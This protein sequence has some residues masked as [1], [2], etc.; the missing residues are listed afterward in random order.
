MMTKNEIDYK[1]VKDFFDADVRKYLPV[2]F[3]LLRKKQIEKFGDNYITRFVE[4]DFYNTDKMAA[5]II[6]K[7]ISNII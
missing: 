3:S 2:Q 4:C 5:G 7:P 1:L 6:N